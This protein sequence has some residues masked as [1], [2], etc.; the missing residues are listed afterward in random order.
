MEEFT[1]PYHSVYEDVPTKVLV[2]EID[3]L[4]K[5]LDIKRKKREDYLKT[6][7]EVWCVYWSILDECY[8]TSLDKGDTTL[9]DLC[10]KGSEKDCD[11][12]LKAMTGKF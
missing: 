4:A 10:Y 8:Y 1:K 7:D 11:D 2:D 3:R 6:L 5:L 9:D 12:Y